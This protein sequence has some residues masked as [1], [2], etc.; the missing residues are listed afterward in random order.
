[1]MKKTISNIGKA[2]FLAVAL[3]G[4]SACSS[5]INMDTPNKNDRVQS[6]VIHYTQENTAETLKLFS[7][8]EASVSAHFVVTEETVYQLADLN[9]RAWHAGK[10]FWRGKNSLNDTSIGI[11]LVY[12]V[13]CNDAANIGYAAEKMTCLYPDYPPAL[14]V[15]L[16]KVLDKIYQ[17]YPNINPVN[18]VAHQDIAPTR[19]SDPGPKFPWQ[20]VYSQGYGAWYNS[21]DYL[22]EYSKLDS[23][24]L[25]SDIFYK[26]L[27]F[28]GYQPAQT[29]NQTDIIK[30]FQTHFTPWLISGEVSQESMAAVL[31]LLKKYQP[32]QYLELTSVMDGFMLLE[33]D[34]TQCP[35]QVEECSP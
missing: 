17:A 22:I 8:P 34:N 10:S 15:N 12:E 3:M 27:E 31:A 6:V 13:D 4:T 1:M 20:Y 9:E 23:Q 7:T 33:P 24:E 25:S 28:Y 32:E 18:I 5:F 35:S 11:E 19:K 29:S 26:A 14:V 30:A 2:S 16:I 21:D